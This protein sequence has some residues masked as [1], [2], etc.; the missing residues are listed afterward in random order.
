[1]SKKL[2]ILLLVI[3]SQIFISSS[4]LLD[5]SVLKAAGCVTLVKK[6]KNKPND[7]KMDTIFLLS[8][9]INIDE[10]TADLLLQNQYYEKIGI[11]ENQ[12]MELI[13]FESIRKRF[14]EEQI[15][16]YSK[17]LNKAL[18]PLKNDGQKSKEEQDSFGYKYSMEDKESSE[19]NNTNFIINI[20]IK[21]LTSTDSLILL[22]GLSIIFY[23]S[24]Q[25]IRKFFSESDND[26]NNINKNKKASKNKNNKK[27]KK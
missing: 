3:F 13:N 16:E 24:L 26:G 18:E 22:C 9:F 4:Q 20:I 1:M 15:S 7:K 21:Y 2:F 19:E 17:A 23:F 27:K 5:K 25:K 10:S 12:I 8:C 14:T 6:L 11:E